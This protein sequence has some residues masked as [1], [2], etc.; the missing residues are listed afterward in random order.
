MIWT[1]EPTATWYASVP[2]NS[3]GYI[4]TSDSSDTT[5]KLK[6]VNVKGQNPST[7]E[8]PEYYGNIGNA[9]Q[10]IFDVLYFE[11]ITRKISQAFEEGE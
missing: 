4:I 11:G 7:S 5:A 3:S 10:Q 8:E 2:L 1:N 9:F 6:T